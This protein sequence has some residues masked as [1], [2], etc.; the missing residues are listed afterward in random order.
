MFLNIHVSQMDACLLL[1]FDRRSNKKIHS[2][3]LVVFHRFAPVQKTDLALSFLA[4]AQGGAQTHDAPFAARYACA[5][6][7]ADTLRA[8]ARGGRH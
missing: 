1:K 4:A 7:A 8:A 6:G 5:T 3:E 2:N